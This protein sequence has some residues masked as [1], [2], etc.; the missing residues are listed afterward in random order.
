[1]A[2]DKYNDKGYADMTAY[3]ALKNLSGEEWEKER[4]RLLRVKAAMDAARGVFKT[5]GFKIIGR[6]NLEDIETGKIYK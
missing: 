5:Y 1:M 2:N 3:Q 6:V 4:R